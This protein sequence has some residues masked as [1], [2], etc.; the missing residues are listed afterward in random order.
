MDGV[1]VDSNPPHRRAWGEFNRRYGIE[2]T[3][4]MHQRMYGKRNDEIVRDFFGDSLS[5]DEVA[6]RGRRK[7][8]LYREMVGGPAR[9][10]LVPG[11][12]DFIIQYQYLQMAVATNAEPEN[13]DFLLDRTPA[14]GF[15]PR[16]CGRATGKRAQTLSG[17]L[18][19]GRGIARHESPEC[20]V[21]FEDSHAGVA[22][23]VAAGMRVIGL[24]TTYVNLPGTALNV[25]NF[26]GGILNYGCVHRCAPIAT[27]AACAC[28]WDRGRLPT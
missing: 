17:Y 28:T 3:P 2:T 18:L 23:A 9:E 21:V 7:E 5:A 1:L 26:L 14:S 16:G 19:T 22:A 12:R 10:M 6:E 20:C 4:E 8:A 27:D 25:D 11:V 24:A 13:V 15:F